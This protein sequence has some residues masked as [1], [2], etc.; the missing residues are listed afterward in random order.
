MTGEETEQVWMIPQRWQLFEYR[1][2]ISGPL[3]I[4]DLMDQAISTGLAEF[5]PALPVGQAVPFLASP[6]FHLGQR[7]GNIFLADKDGGEEFTRADEESLVMFA[8]PA[9]LDIANARTYRDEQQPRNDLETLV[10]TSPVGVAAFDARAAVPSSLNREAM[11]IVES[12]REPE[13]SH[14]ELLGVVTCVRANRRALSFLNFPMPELLSAG[15][16]VRSEEIVLRVPDGRSVNVL[17][18]A[19]PTHYKTSVPVGFI[20]NPAPL[21][22]GHRRQYSSPASR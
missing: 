5:R 18:N 6:V 1:G 22:R 20:D 14:Q 17:L 8:S 19:T 16:T 4:P 10:K 11:R 12:L 21:E 15:A 9:A 13:Q 7:V 2:C 3:R